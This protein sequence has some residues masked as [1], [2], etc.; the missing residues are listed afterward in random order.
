MEEFI[1]LSVQLHLLF[2]I[3]LVVL[4]I[5]NLYLLKSDSVFIKLSK[6]LELIAPQYYI[7]LSAIFFT[8]II[9]MAVKKFEFSLSV[10]IMILVWLFILVKGIKKHKI[11]KKMEKR[12][13]N[14]Q[15]DYKKLAIKKYTIDAILIIVTI[16]FT[17]GVH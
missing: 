5:I 8:G 17:Y 3:S 13:E 9:V 15:V 7:V 4:I 10:W 11:Y 1:A 2:V 14:S 16:I 12:D 6:K